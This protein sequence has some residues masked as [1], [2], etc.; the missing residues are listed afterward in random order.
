MCP[1]Q[2]AYTIC[3]DLVTVEVNT[4]LVVWLNVKVISTKYSKTDFIFKIEDQELYSIY[5]Y[6]EKKRQSLTDS[7]T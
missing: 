7:L 1:E 5:L 6:K 3:N 4:L 2:Y